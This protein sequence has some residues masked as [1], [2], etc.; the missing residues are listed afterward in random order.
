MLTYAAHISCLP[1]PSYR[2]MPTQNHRHG[3]ERAI[4]ATTE[5]EIIQYT[6]ENIKHMRPDERRY[7]DIG[8]YLF[9]GCINVYK[10][11]VKGYKHY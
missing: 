1:L 6:P 3:Q 11:Q 9:S 4:S 8:Q 7:Y 5:V 2:D 10:L